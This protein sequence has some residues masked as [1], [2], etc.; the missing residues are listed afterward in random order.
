MLWENHNLFT[1][2]SFGVNYQLWVISH[3]YP[4]AVPMVVSPTQGPQTCLVS[5][6]FPFNK[7]EVPNWRTP[8]S[9]D[10][11]KMASLWFS[12]SNFG[13]SLPNGPLTTSCLARKLKLSVSASCMLKPRISFC[14]SGICS[15][16]L[17]CLG[18]ITNQSQPE[19]YPLIHFRVASSF[20]GPSWIRSRFFRPLTPPPPP[21]TLFVQLFPAPSSGSAGA[22]PGR[23]GRKGN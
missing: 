1:G 6:S 22:S 11:D 17:P 13:E 20:S 3:Q 8:P 16:S 5:F 21:R 15:A 14:C 7:T 12:W 19:K 18:K 23:L 9:L 10:L 4:L 2:S